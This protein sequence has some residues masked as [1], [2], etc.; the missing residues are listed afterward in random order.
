MY[1]RFFYNILRAKIVYM[2][3][4]D[5]KISIL[6]RFYCIFIAFKLKLKKINFSTIWWGKDFIFVIRSGYIFLTYDH[7]RIE[8][9]LYNLMASMP[10]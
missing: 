4:F 1:K 3:L 6:M 8:T 7:F 10:N 2:D 9:Y 5:R